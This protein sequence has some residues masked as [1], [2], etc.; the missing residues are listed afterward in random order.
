MF[1]LGRVVLEARSEQYFRWGDSRN[2][3]APCF[4]TPDFYTPAWEVEAPLEGES[5][6]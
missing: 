1:A 4:R 2:R 3:L 5:F 6:N